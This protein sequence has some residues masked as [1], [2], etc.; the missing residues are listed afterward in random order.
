MTG[1]GALGG[2][3]GL[4]ADGLLA[5]KVGGSTTL[6]PFSSSGGGLSRLKPGGSRDAGT[7]DGVLEPPSALNP[8]S[9]RTKRKKLALNVYKQ[10]LYT[11]SQFTHCLMASFSSSEMR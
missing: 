9:K 10:I 6:G 2:P 11:F 8:E 7:L 5:P 3:L 4:D 1:P